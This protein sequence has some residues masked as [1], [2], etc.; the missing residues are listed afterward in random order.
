VHGL[1][2]NDICNSLCAIEPLKSGKQDL[3][4]VGLPRTRGSNHHETVLDLLNLIELKNLGNPSFSIDKAT[5][6]ANLENL[7]AQS[8]EVDRDI[9]S[10]GE[11]IGKQ[12]SQSKSFTIMG[13]NKL[14]L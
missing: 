1:G 13:Q 3:P 11:D 4:S 5:F 14:T 10:A 7:L 6:R 8:I 2:V 9:I 12:A